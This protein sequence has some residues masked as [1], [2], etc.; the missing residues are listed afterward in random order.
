MRM[1]EVVNTFYATVYKRANVN[2]RSS[3]IGEDQD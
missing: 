3:Q 1:M 2:G